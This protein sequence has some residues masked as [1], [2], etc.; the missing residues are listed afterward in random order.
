MIGIEHRGEPIRDPKW[1]T[2]AG[3]RESA[4]R[5]VEQVSRALKN[6]RAFYDYIKLGVSFYPLSPL[7]FAAHDGMHN[8]G[9]FEESPQK[10]SRACLKAIRKGRYPV[11]TVIAAS[12]FMSQ[13]VAVAW[14]AQPEESL[15]TGAALERIFGNAREKRR[16][17][18][19][20]GALERSLSEYSPF[21]AYLTPQGRVDQIVGHTATILIQPERKATALDQVRCGGS[22]GTPSA[23]GEAVA[24]ALEVILA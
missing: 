1:L 14:L 5:V 3:A 9:A 4:A 13:R 23:Y 22:M 24:K 19:V 18:D 6:A 7:E 12:V 20:I 21:R 16:P 10:F 15:F 2:E 11:P 8:F 17:D